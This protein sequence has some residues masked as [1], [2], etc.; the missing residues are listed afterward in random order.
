MRLRERG[1]PHTRVIISSYIR[2]LG[3]GAP[4]RLQ[5]GCSLIRARRH[6]VSIEYKHM[7]YS[8]GLTLIFCWDR[9]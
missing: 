7:Q 3:E 4:V 2:L 1:H 9:E 8:S 6:I 5:N